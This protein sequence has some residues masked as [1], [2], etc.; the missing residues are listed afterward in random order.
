MEGDRQTRDRKDVIS[1]STEGYYVLPD[2]FPPP[3]SY[4]YT[5][6]HHLVMSP[7]A[8]SSQSIGEVRVQND[9]H[10]TPPTSSVYTNIDEV[11][12][13]QRRRD[14]AYMQIEDACVRSDGV[15][16]CEPDYSNVYELDND[17]YVYAS[18][19]MLVS[20]TRKDGTC[21]E[22]VTKPQEHQYDP[23]IIIRPKSNSLPG[24]AHSKGHTYVNLKSSKT[25]K[26][27]TSKPLD[28]HKRED[29]K[30]HFGNETQNPMYSST[31]ELDIETVNPLYADSSRMRDEALMH[32]NDSKTHKVGRASSS[33]DLP[34]S[35]KDYFTSTREWLEPPKTTRMVINEEEG[36]LDHTYMG[37][38]V[39]ERVDPDYSYPKPSAKTRQVTL[40]GNPKQERELRIKRTY[41]LDNAYPGY[42]NRAMWLPEKEGGKPRVGSL[43]QENRSGYMGL[44]RTGYE[45]AY[46]NTF[47]LS[48][49]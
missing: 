19:H 41:S 40:S 16:D 38:L 34:T 6:T 2:N 48:Q 42:E 17:K 12:I 36:F 22:V 25:V 5:K 31:D 13:P 23:I 26:V 21:G 10:Q 43:S 49:V 33:R 20:P 24:S 14:S 3:S 9:H 37:I 4:S 29:V 44:Y 47:S 39:R 1:V 18:E 15:R 7:T 32:Q 35:D 46:N 8:K 11:I 45:S 30:F 27:S 28:P